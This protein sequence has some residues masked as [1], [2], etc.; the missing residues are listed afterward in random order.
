MT[1][2]GSAAIR[3]QLAPPSSRR[4][5][6]ARGRRARKLVHLLSKPRF[7][8][9]LRHGVAATIEHNTVPFRQ[10]VSSVI[11]VGAHH[12]QFALFALQRF[13]TAQIVCIEPLERARSK[14]RAAVGGEARV[15]IV[16][17]AAAKEAG[18]R[19]LHIS[20]RSDS[21][22]L[23]SITSKYTMAFPGTEEAAV[24]EVRTASLDELLAN[25]HLPP[26]TLLKIDVQGGELEVLGGATTT[27]HQTDEIFVECSFLEFY[28]G[29]PLIGEVIAYVE[30]CGFTLSG[31]YSLVRDG[32]FRCLQADLLFTRRTTAYAR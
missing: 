10:D 13:P 18:T 31:I 32:D 21:S 20:R 30:S 8:R 7:R 15:E 22:S 3:N 27:L 19:P 24:V 12:G 26:P 1:A 2:V 25:I 14:I 9:G 5:R 16:P 6:K 4:A 23:L 11:D 17:G 28:S 29:Q